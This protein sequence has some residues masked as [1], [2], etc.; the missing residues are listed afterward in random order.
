MLVASHVG[1]SRDHRQN[2]PGK[3]KGAQFPCKEH[4]PLLPPSSLFSLP[5]NPHPLSLPP[6]SSTPPS[7]S[8]GMSNIFH[9]TLISLVFFRS[10]TPLTLLSSGLARTFGRAAFA[11]PTPVARAFQPLR[12]NALP[13][14]SARFASSDA[15]QSGK[16]HQVIGAVVDGTWSPEHLTGCG[17]WWTRKSFSWSPIHPKGHRNR[18]QSYLLDDI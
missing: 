12:S 6:R 16:I 11:R 4:Q 2:R 7:C 10:R 3:A 8:R 18:S 5:P 15:A 17:Y 1:S 9:L 13:A 14:L